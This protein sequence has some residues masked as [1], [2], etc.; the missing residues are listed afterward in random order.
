MSKMTNG[1]PNYTMSL[2]STRYEI[3][4]NLNGNIMFRTE[5]KSVQESR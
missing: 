2:K 5:Q 1:V 3:K 4:I